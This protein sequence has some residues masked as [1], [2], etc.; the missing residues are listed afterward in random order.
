MATTSLPMV[1]GTWATSTAP[2]IVEEFV[3]I[4]A[5]GR[6]DVGDVNLVLCPP[7]ASLPAVRASTATANIALGAPAILYKQQMGEREPDDQQKADLSAIMLSWR[8]KYVIVGHSQWKDDNTTVAR[9]TAAALRH[10]MCPIICIVHNR[11]HRRQESFDSTMKRQIGCALSDITPRQSEQPLAIAY[12]PEW[13]GPE[14]QTVADQEAGNVSTAIRNVLGEKLGPAA[15]DNTPLLYGGHV[16]ADNATGFADAGFDGVLISDVSIGAETF[17][18]I[19]CTLS[20]R[21]LTVQGQRPRTS[22]GP[23]LDSTVADDVPFT[24]DVPPTEELQSVKLLLNRSLL[25]VITEL[26]NALRYLNEREAQGLEMIQEKLRD[27]QEREHISRVGE[28]GEHFDPNIH[29][30]I[31]MDERGEYQSRVVVEVLQPGYRVED[32]VVQ[33]AEVIVN[34]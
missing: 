10:G 34:R 5:T 18:E 9:E 31:G 30:V 17:L 2:A 7:F 12:Q 11:E 4:V 25:P 32:L 3:D 20:D 8:F 24:D 16:N 27:F 1:V 15:A 13:A 6:H 26:E 28:V 22:P 14:N 33:K 19:A 21:Q 29:R 23:P